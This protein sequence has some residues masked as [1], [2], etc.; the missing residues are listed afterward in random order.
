MDPGKEA[1]YW[2]ARLSHGADARDEHEFESWRD[3]SLENA[4][5]YDRVASLHDR[6]RELGDAPEIL[7]LRRETLARLAARRRF[8]KRVKI[9]LGVAL[10]IALIACLVLALYSEKAAARPAGV[11]SDAGAIGEQSFR[12]AG[13][14]LALTLDDGS[15][16]VLN[17][18]SRMRILYTKKQ[19]R[20]ALDQGQGWIVAARDDSRPFF[21]DAGGQ[22]VEAQGTEFGVRVMPGDNEVMVI[23]GA[24]TVD[25]GRPGHGGEDVA[26][27]PSQLS[28]ASGKSTSG[29]RVIDADSRGAGDRRP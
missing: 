24:G 27:P 15:S 14:R 6:I 25:P 8:R 2:H 21:V 23:E 18:A 26:M 1:A 12:T 4:D 29:S 19:R 9:A 5:A 10:A 17:A 28:V 16:V 3:A 11:T 20:L 13:Q 7:S 22:R